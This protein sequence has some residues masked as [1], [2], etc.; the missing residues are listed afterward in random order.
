MAEEISLVERIKMIE[1]LYIITP[2]I[3]QALETIRICRDSGYKPYE[4]YCMTIEGPFGSGKTELATRVVQGILND[5]A[6]T[7]SAIKAVLLTTPVNPTEKK[8]SQ[9]FF[10]GLKIPFR[11]RTDAH[12]MAETIKRNIDYFRP[13]LIFIDEI[14]HFFDGQ[15]S[16]L[17]ISACD[18]LKQIIK[19]SSAPIILMGLDGKVAEFLE[20]NPQLGSLFINTHHMKNFNWDEKKPES[21]RYLQEFLF[22]VEDGFHLK[23]PSNLAETSM[24]Q[25]LFLASKG[26]KRVLMRLLIRA[27]KQAIQSGE[28]KI[29]LSILSQ[30]WLQIG[31]GPGSSKRNPFSFG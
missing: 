27:A 30:V 8:L 24:A 18:H 14:Q 11:G 17:I 9:E 7:Q 28:E 6:E 2:E 20:L 4:P 21:I 12:I 23:Y 22:H 1:N 31:R 3:K 15:T 13:E 25:K 29:N 5:Y 26:V 16:R 10:F 19:Q